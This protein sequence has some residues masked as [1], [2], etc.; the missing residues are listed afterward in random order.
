MAVDIL[1]GN[2]DNYW[3]N[4]NNYYLYFNPEDNRFEFIPYDYDNTFGIDWVGQDWGERDVNNWGQNKPLTNRILE[5]E[6]YRNR[7]NFYVDKIIEE[8]FNE[9]VLFSE[10]DRLK[11][12]TEDAA[13]EDTYRTLDYGY[14]IGEYHASFNSALGGHVDYGLKPYIT[15]RINSALDQLQL[16]NIPPII[17]KVKTNFIF[18]D[19]EETLTIKATVLDDDANPTIT[20]HIKTDNTT[21]VSLLDDG[22]GR[23]KDANDGVYTGIFVPGDFEGILEFYITASDADE[24]QGRFP[25]NPDKNLLQNIGASDSPLVI[26]ELMASNSTTIQDEGGAFADWLEIYNPSDSPISMD[27]YFLT[28]NLTV[29]NKWAFPDTTI[30]PSGFLLVWV[31]DDEE[32]GSLHASFNLSKEGEDIGLFTESEGVFLT[33]HAF[34]FP[35]LETDFS[36]GRIGNLNEEFVVFDTPTPGTQNGVINSTENDFDTPSGIQLFQN[37]PNPF[38]PETTISF[39]LDKPTELSLEIYTIDGR[40]VQTLANSRYLSGT[41][42]IRFDASSLSSGMYFYWLKTENQSLTKRLILIK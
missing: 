29:K 21:I 1:T 19:N 16:E 42:S 36:Y 3:Y 28:D 25:N 39:Q 41:H 9:E 38:N 5:V 11:A 2:W 33:V 15:T 13:E 35:S 17:K 32:E 24:K 23:D 26:N 8:V 14:G 20:A 37:Y 10:I 40:L 4:Q 27:G 6:E 7:L 22:Q 12:L 18:V 34:A 30:Q 31:D